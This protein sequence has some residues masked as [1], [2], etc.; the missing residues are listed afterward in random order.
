MV[1]C[2]FNYNKMK[3]KMQRKEEEICG[4]GVEQEIEREAILLG[5][6][7]RVA[8]L[9]DLPLTNKYPSAELPSKKRK[10]K[11]NP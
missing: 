6:T 3:R 11:I 9:P 5:R 7:K 2:L 1:Y 4:W 8:M 10:P